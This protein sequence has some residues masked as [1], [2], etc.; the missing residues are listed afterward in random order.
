MSPEIP[1]AVPLAWLAPFVALLA[2]IAVLPLVAPHFWE[3]HRNKA[4]VAALL[5]A[6]VAW[7]AWQADRAALAETGHDYLAFMLLLG[8][9]FVVAGGIFLDGDLRATPGVNT[10]F[11]LLG[12]LLA[13]VVGT[14]G[15]AMLLIRPLLRTNAERRHVKH[16]VIFFVFLVCNI[17]GCLTPLGDPPLFV[18]FLRGVPFLWTLRLWP[19]WLGM[20][21]VLLA[22]YFAWD[23]LAVRH[24]TRAALRLDRVR[25]DP[26]RLTGRVNLALLAGLVP[27]VALAA[28]GTREALLLGITLL[29]LALTPAGVRA[30]NAFTWHPLVEVGVL[31]AG[32][33]VTMLPALAFLRE[34]GPALG[35][36]SPRQ[37]FWV[38]GSLSSV[39]D[40]T[41]TYLALLALAQGLDL[42]RQVAG[43]SH[44][45]LTGIS[46]GAVFMGAVTYI[47]NAPNFMVKSIAERSG[48]TM[49]G[50]GGYL[51]YSVAI[52]GPLFLALAWLAL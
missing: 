30:R 12:A 8:A 24:E 22:I 9:L 1:L 36:H 21:A 20:N 15:A 3:P 5:S 29:S 41:P 46:L 23:T 4:A 10:T 44:E 11:L 49:P 34:H 17:G 7:W 45:V 39:L 48:V 47:G 51:L 32:L 27:T 28:P 40:N 50:F 42:P 14:T 13:N 33:F 2:A 52:L 16:T 37:F 43:V 31:F 19:E 38:T 6:P 25:V 26:L 35:V 18:G